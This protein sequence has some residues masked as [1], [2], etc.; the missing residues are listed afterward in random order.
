MSQLVVDRSDIGALFEVLIT[1]GYTI[2]GPTVQDAAIVYDQ[3]DGV[4]D[5]PIGWTDDQDGGHY[6]LL[7][8]DDQ[9]L[10]GY[11]VGQHSW[12]KLLFPP[13][14][15]L[16]EI[17]RANGSLEF[18]QSEV[19]ETR[20]AFLGVRACELAAISIQ[21][22]VFLGSGETDRTYQTARRDV[23][24]VAI[25]CMVAGGTCFC[26][27]MGT[28]P[29]CTSG[30]DLVM[31]EVIDADRHEFVLE[32]GSEAGEVVLSRLHGRAAA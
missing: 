12:K 14:V 10:F 2:M 16:L 24:T 6:R 13:R 9:A 30:Y 3:L 20:Y 1:D 26:V 15:T 11:A 28:G 21:D 18:V 32:A 5:L 17:S 19:P 31:T 8:R 27:S 4:E 29:R 23:F 25:N 7:P 22:K